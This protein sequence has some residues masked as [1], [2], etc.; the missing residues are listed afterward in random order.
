MPMETLQIRLSREQLSFI[1]QKV[2]EGRYPS[3]SEAIRDYLR[4]AQLWEALERIL[5]L[6]H[7]EEDEED[8][9]AR[10]E[11]IREKVYKERS[12]K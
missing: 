3:R 9:L 10:L 1:D 12:S 11:R 2:R 5:E 4:K 7:S 8:L 6:G